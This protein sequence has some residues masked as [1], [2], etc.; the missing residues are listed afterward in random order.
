ML[1]A[2]AAETG[3][4]Q[5]T[6]FTV[7]VFK[8]YFVGFAALNNRIALGA[9]DAYVAD[10]IIHV[11]IAA[12]LCDGSADLHAT[13][14]MQTEAAVIAATDIF[15]L[16]LCRCLEPSDNLTLWQCFSAEGNEVRTCI[17]ETAVY[18]CVCQSDDTLVVGHLDFEIVCDIHNATALPFQL[19]VDIDDVSHMQIKPVIVIG[20][21]GS[22]AG[23]KL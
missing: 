17:K 22:S 18:L 9:I 5:P 20:K 13:E 14:V 6:D 1:A 11:I 4:N 10:F 19:A 7:E 16:C 21:R 2:V 3:A 12:A 8:F 15:I 23:P